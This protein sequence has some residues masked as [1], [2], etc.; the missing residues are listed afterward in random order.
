MIRFG[1][2]NAGRKALIAVLPLAVVASFAS[3]G[4]ASATD[5]TEQQ[6]RWAEGLTTSGT[7]EGLDFRTTVSPDLGT[8]STTLDNGRFA[9]A[10]DGA[11]AT[12][13][14]STG[15][16]VSE[17]PLRLQ[18]VAGN[19]IPLLPQVSTDGHTLSLMPQVSPAAAADLKDITT[20][21]NAGNS[22]PVLNGAAAGAVIGLAFALVSCIPALSLIIIG[23]IAC[24]PFAA[25]SYV[26]PMAA[27]GA[28]VGAVAPQI[29]PQVLP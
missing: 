4:T 15:T 17:F 18:T 16:K 7:V 26:I 11:V 25:L 8:I 5:Y 24:V 6:A 14:S 22:D 28:I 19:T 20:D 2:R 12:I 21:P 13:E 10:A 1:F 9:M 27:V 3:A 23:Y 29:I